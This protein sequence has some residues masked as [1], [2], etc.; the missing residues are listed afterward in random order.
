MEC[1]YSFGGNPNPSFRYQI[2]VKQ[3]TGPAYQW[4]LDYDTNDDPF[5]R[6][7]VAWGHD[8]LGYDIVSFE[9]QEPSIMFALKFGELL[10]G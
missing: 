9:W 3:C 4:C 6:F 8:K 2:K 10:Y 7:H 5:K 1:F